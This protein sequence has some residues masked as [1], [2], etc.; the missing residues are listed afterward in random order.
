MDLLHGTESYP[1]YFITIYKGKDSE[2][3]Y[4]CVCMFVC[5]CKTESLC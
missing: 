5:V 2:K 4:M 1:Q 3:E